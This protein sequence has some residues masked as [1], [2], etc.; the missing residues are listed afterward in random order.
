ML[1]N[2]TYALKT[3]LVKSSVK[4]LAQQRPPILQLCSKLKRLF[5]L[6]ISVFYLI[7]ASSNLAIASGFP[8]RTIDGQQ[9]P[10]L[11]PIIKKTAPAVVNIATYTLQHAYN[12]LQES[13]FFRHFFSLPEKIEETRKVQSAGSGV[14]VNADEGYVLTNYHVI[15]GSDDIEVKLQDG[16]SFKAKLIGSDKKVDIALLKIKGDHFSAIELADSNSLEVG[17]FVVAIGNPFGLGQTVTSGIVSALGRNGL[18]IEGY[19]DFIQ[20]D[21]SINPGNSGGALIDMNGRLVGIN[22]AIIAPAGGNVGIGFAIP[23]EVAQSAMSQLLEFGEVRRGGIGARFQDLSPELA[24]AFELDSAITSTYQGAIIASVTPGSA[25]EEAGLK[26]GDVIISANERIIHNANDINNRI[27]LTPIGKRLSLSLI[28]DGD[29]LQTDTKIKPIPI[30]EIAGEILSAYL[31]GAHLMDMIL[32]D[33]EESTGIIVKDI[34]ANSY[35]EQL[36]LKSGDVIY[37]INRT[38]IRSIEQ[39]KHFLSQRSVQAFRL[40]RGYQDLILYVH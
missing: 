7:L 3:R 16:R 2:Y 6:T 1:Q 15:K 34:A 37:G 21:A 9:Q 25:A 39:L 17:D 31:K 27:G 30:P 36:G 24:H 35:T 11:A 14:I 13:P 26:T 38:R 33:Q 10:S 40:R 8:Q 23:T 29:T 5:I 18:G 20:T 12:P 22:S 4:V 19:E 28:R 32:N